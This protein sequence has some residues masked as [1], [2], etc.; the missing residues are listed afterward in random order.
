MFAPQ[1]LTDKIERVLDFGYYLLRMNMG[2][3]AANS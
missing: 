1:F 3:S 2:V